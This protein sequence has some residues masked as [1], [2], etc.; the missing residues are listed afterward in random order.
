MYQVAG[1]TDYFYFYVKMNFAS[2]GAYHGGE[3]ITQYKDEPGL[4]ASSF[5]IAGAQSTTSGDIIIWNQPT[6]ELGATI[7]SKNIFLT[8]YTGARTVNGAITE[9]WNH[10]KKWNL[11]G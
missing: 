7:P 1:V 6:D 3:L 2:Q 10:P 5:M 4:A 8:G 9:N 11:Y